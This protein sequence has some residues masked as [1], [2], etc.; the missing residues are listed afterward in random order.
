MIWWIVGGVLGY[1]TLSSLW[2]KGGAAEPP[3]ETTPPSKSLEI[4]TKDLDLEPVEDPSTPSASVIFDPTDIVPIDIPEVPG[5]PL[6]TPPADLP[7]PPAP[8]ESCLK[9]FSPSGKINTDLTELAKHCTPEFK[10]LLRHSRTFNEGERIVTEFAVIPRRY[11][12]YAVGGDGVSEINIQIVDPT[13]GKALA[14]DDTSGAT[15]TAGFTVKDAAPG[16]KLALV[17]EVPAGV[18]EVAYGLWAEPFCWSLVTRTGDAAADLEALA[19]HCA[20]G[21]T[22]ITPVASID[23]QA[24]TPKILPLFLPPGSYRIMA[25]A[26][27][28]IADLDLELLDNTGKAISADLTPNDALPIVPPHKLL[29]LTDPKQLSLK[30]V[31]VKGSGSVMFAVWRVVEPVS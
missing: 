13:T 22:P 23:V 18:G 21:M 7:A 24:G 17:V 6:P 31:A 9:T 3:P 4:V 29:T 10:E 5:I 1:W 26:S 14:S 20:V 28:S 27:K 30:F 16:A 8:T 25:A 19:S 15:T 2:S 11:R 12:A